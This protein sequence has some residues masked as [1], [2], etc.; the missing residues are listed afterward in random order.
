MPA[1]SLASHRF[2][3]SE[4]QAR[5]AI[6]GKHDIGILNSGFSETHCL[7]ALTTDSPYHTLQYQKKTVE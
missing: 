7:M 3:T 4:Q 2:Q 6:T 1:L 5:T